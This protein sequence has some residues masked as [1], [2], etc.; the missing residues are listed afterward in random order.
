MEFQLHSVMAQALSGWFS[1]GNSRVLTT[2]IYAS[3]FQEHRWVLWSY[4]QDLDGGDNIPWF[5]GGD[6]NIIRP[7]GEKI[8]GVCHSSR[9]RDEFNRCIQDCSLVDL[10]Y[11]GNRFSW[12]NGRLGGGRIWARLDRVL[13][14]TGFLSSF[15]NSCLMYLPRTSSDHCPMITSLWVDMRV[16]PI[17]FRFQRMWCLHED[18]L[19][20]VSEYWRQEFQGCPMVKFSKKI[21]K[22][23]QVLKKW[24]R[25]VF[26]KVE[27]DLKVIKEE[28]LELEN[29][30]QHNYTQDMEVE[31]LRCKQKHLQYLQREEIMGCQKSKVKWICEGD[32]NTAFF[33]AS[34]RC[35]KKFKALESMALED[36]SVL[37]S[38][39]AV[40]EGAVD[41]FQQQL[42]TSAVSFEEPSMNLITPIITEDDNQFLCRVPNLMEVKEA[43]WSIPQDSSPGPDGFSTS[44]F[45]HAWDIIKEDLLMLAI[46][47]FEGKPL[48]TFFGATNIV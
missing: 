17:P 21:K 10:P 40:L 31:I 45:H 32:E 33:H 22:L 25:E 35:K 36:G 6:F 7:E 12:C 28:L 34:L 1:I 42:T 2:F 5:L 8:G 27:V 30:V 39:Q 44:F 48:T 11:S 24:N 47:F 20:V 15:P 3:C 19:G 16:G 26:G 29:N 4:L 37:D 13:V 14:N 18:F 9:G 46:E 23:K 38:G 41:F 43:L